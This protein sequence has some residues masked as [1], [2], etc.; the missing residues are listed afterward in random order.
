MYIYMYIYIYIYIYINMYIGVGVDH[1]GGGHGAA[2]QARLDLH[3][4][5]H[6][7]TD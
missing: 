3:P 5:V 4:A 1:V 6:C 2:R 7:S